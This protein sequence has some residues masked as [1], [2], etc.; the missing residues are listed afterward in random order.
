MKSW[1]A[2][3]LLAVMWLACTGSFA[4]NA[5]AQ[6]LT[7][8]IGGT[9]VDDQKAVLPGATVSVRNTNT[10]LVRTAMT[11]A[12]GS[13]V[14]PNLVAG[15]Y[16]VTVTLAGFKTYVQRALVLTATERLSLPPVAL[17]VGG[18][19]ESIKVE[20]STIR[21]QTQSGE[22]SAGINAPSRTRILFC[23]GGR[24]A[25]DA[26]TFPRSSRSASGR[27]TWLGMR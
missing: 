11:D 13:F 26:M 19:E 25:I 23:S 27:E 2:K 4:H 17:E 21:V 1:M 16:D 5:S 14:I 10:Q 9:V 7:G 8:Q 20:A 18:I 3:V 12:S 6:T 15:T 24:F 22:R